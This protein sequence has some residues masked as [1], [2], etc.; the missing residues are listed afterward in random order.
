MYGM[1]QQTTQHQDHQVSLIENFY[2]FQFTYKSY[3]KAI[4][5]PLL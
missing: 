4:P 2:V 5:S 3:Y 1:I